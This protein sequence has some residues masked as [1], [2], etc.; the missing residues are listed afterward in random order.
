MLSFYCLFLFAKEI[1]VNCFQIFLR[2]SIGLCLLNLPII[3]KAQN[4]SIE[5]KITV[6]PN[7]ASTLY[8]YWNNLFIEKPHLI[9]RTGVAQEVVLIENPYPIRIISGDLLKNYPNGKYTSFVVYPE[10]SLTISK[11]YNNN[12][13][14][15]ASNDT[16]RN[17]ELA[18]FGEMATKIG[19]FEGFM[20]G[21]HPIMLTDEE[22]IKTTDK[23]WKNRMI[24]LNQYALKKTISP[25]FKS[26][27]ENSFYYTKYSDI[28]Y[29]YF[30]PRNIS[31]KKSNSGI[32]NKVAQELVL[33]D[34]YFY[35]LEYRSAVLSYVSYLAKDVGYDS[36]WSSLFTTAF[37]NLKDKTREIILFD[38]IKL[39]SQEEHPDTIKKMID[40]YLS[41]A[42]NGY[43]KEYIVDNFS[44]QR[45]K[46]DLNITTFLED[47]I[48]SYVNMKSL[49]WEE[50][51]NSRKGSITY[52]DFWAS[53]CG[54]CR[55]EM[56]FS[57]KIKQHYEGQKI[58]FVYISIDDILTSWKKA[59]KQIGIPESNSY[60]LSNSKKNLIVKHFKI[61]SIPRYMII[62]K[63]GKVINADAPRPSDP[64]IR[65]LFDE[66]LKK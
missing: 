39:A 11:D 27:L 2:F 35:L 59:S 46:I 62:G 25:F 3:G 63:D 9:E 12:T 54:P 57:K 51:I 29:P 52:V 61:S 30:S 48:L 65:E 24:F 36:K 1:S 34:E 17:N 56:P 38:I 31:K 10:E 26:Y 60:L 19:E 7:K 44:E 21:Y 13:V 32:V 18:F 15:K 45:L 64:K 28:L 33:N 20:V 55:A 53:W 14:M 8:F 49:S 6:L 42:N 40:V 47:N 5:S 50:F 23:V 41:I 37:N 66:L 58:D 16:I 4:E 43:L 22:L